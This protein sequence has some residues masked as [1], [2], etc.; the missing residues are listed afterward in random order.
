MARAGELTAEQW[1]TGW[2]AADETVD[3][4]GNHFTM[5]EDLA[6]VTAR[7][8]DAWVDRLPAGGK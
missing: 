8:V 6:G 4:S 3:V 1:Q 2:S 5:M 7:T